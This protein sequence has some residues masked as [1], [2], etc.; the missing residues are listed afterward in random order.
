MSAASGLVGA[1]PSAR[2]QCHFVSTVRLAV[3]I[4]LALAHETV[5]A[6]PSGEGLKEPFAT[7][8]P[9]RSVGGDEEAV[10]EGCDGTRKPMIDVATVSCRQWRVEWSRDGKVWGIASAES[11]EEVLRQREATLAFARL[12]TRFGAGNPDP[13]YRDPSPPI[14]DLCGAEKTAASGLFGDGQRFGGSEARRALEAARPQ[15]EALE[16]ALYDEHLPRYREIARLGHEPKTAAA[17]KKYM[18]DLRGSLVALAQAKL[19]L[20][21]ANVLRSPSFLRGTEKLIGGKVQA[22]ERDFEAL[23]AAVAKE[24]QRAYG[25]TYNQEG[26]DAQGKS[27]LV[28][29]D[30]TKVTA[31]FQQGT[32]KSTWFEGTVNLDG[33]ITG[34]SL[35]APPDTPLR[36]SDHT[37]ACGYQRVRAVL[38]FSERSNAPKGQTHAVELWFQQREWVRAPIFSR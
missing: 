28:T 7:D 21:D 25:G 11:L 24:V 14:C 16:K 32:A 2:L 33:S 19:A 10:T 12:D 18:A 9:G 23:Q 27:L 29:L 22:L 35:V 4:L 30:G 38:R 36:C 31:T 1:R 6:A 20:E 5:A 13:R 8:G 34:Q 37:E 26:P 3:V 17:A 15:V